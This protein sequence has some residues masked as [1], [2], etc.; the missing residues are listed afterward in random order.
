MLTQEQIAYGQQKNREH[1][2]NQAKLERMEYKALQS[3]LYK[4][5]IKP[6]NDL[7]E[8]MTGVR[9]KSLCENSNITPW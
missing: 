7:D 8:D 1:I 9:Y 5:P 3:K 4:E 2:W 6:W